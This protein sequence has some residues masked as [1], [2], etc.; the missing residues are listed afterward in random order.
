MAK[1][2]PS[3]NLLLLEDDLDD[4]EILKE[5]LNDLKIT[6]ELIFYHGPR[7]LGLP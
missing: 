5:I 7:C 6:N 3:Y 4:Q 2:W 1:I